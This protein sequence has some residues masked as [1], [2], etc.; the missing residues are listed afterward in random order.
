MY[1]KVKMNQFKIPKQN[2]FV[3][4]FLF[5]GVLF[6]WFGFF[7]LLGVKNPGMQVVRARRRSTVHQ[8][9]EELCIVSTA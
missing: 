1:A 2:L 9:F 5:V 7:S 3:C 6:V 8:L 4:C